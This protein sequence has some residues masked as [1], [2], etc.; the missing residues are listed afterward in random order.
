[1]PYE[2]PYLRYSALAPG[3]A[4]LEEG[5]L[6]CGFVSSILMLL[7]DSNIRQGRSFLAV[8]SEAEFN[9]LSRR[10]D[11]NCLFFPAGDRSS[12]RF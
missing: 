12:R 9:A 11:C 1:M 2:I 3:S 7:L 10:N 5:I 8:G 4:Q 6:W